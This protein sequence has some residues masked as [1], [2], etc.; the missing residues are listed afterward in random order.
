MR[1]VLQLNHFILSNIHFGLTVQY[2]SRTN[3]NYQISN[4]SDTTNATLILFG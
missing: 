3:I 2:L 4:K 1:L